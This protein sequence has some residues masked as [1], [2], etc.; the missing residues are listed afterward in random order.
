MCGFLTRMFDHNSKTYHKGFTL[1]I[2]EITN[3]YHIIPVGF[4]LIASTNPNSLT[5]PKE[6]NKKM[7]PRS[8]NAQT[9]A[10]KNRTKAYQQKMNV[11]IK[12]LKSTKCALSKKLIIKDLLIDSW[13][14]D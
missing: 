12:M 6:I 1:L 13:F 11:L 2:L 4:T 9:K 3:R 5:K 7:E 14:S 8:V 10:G